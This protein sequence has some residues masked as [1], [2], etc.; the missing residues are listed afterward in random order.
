MIDVDDER[1]ARA[2][3][4]CP[5]AFWNYPRR[6]DG[7]DNPNL[8]DPDGQAFWMVEREPFDLDQWL[9]PHRYCEV[10]V[11]ISSMHNCVAI[12]YHAGYALTNGTNV[13]HLGG[14]YGADNHPDRIGGS[15]GA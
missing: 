3:A 1:E 4:E 8:R 12:G 9:G 11:G 2:F 15:Y 14:S 10:A 7:I 6:W 5:S 13:T